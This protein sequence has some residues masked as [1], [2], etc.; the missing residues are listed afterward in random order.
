MAS[1][2]D[3]GSCSNFHTVSTSGSNITLSDDTTSRSDSAM[4]SSSSLEGDIIIE[5]PVP[6]DDTGQ[7]SHPVVVGCPQGNYT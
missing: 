2:S 5:L 7:E 1:D 3:Y 6:L 4:G